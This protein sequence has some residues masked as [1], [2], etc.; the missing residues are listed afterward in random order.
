MIFQLGFLLIVIGGFAGFHM[1]KCRR[2]FSMPVF[3][4]VYAALY[5]VVGIYIYTNE[6]YLGMGSDGLDE[7]W[8]LA[9]VAVISFNLG[10]V[11]FSKRESY[12]LDPQRPGYLP[13]YNALLLVVIFAL[14]VELFVILSVGPYNYFFIS[15]LDRFPIMKQ[16]QPLLYLSNL[17]NIALPFILARYFHTKSRADRNLLVFVLVHNFA[18]AILLISRS[19]LA[20]NFICLFFF[21]ELHG[22]VRKK[23]LLVLGSAMAVLMFFYKGIL[24]GVILDKEYQSFNPGEFINWIRN[25]EIMMNSAFD[26]SWLPNN[27]YFLAFKSMFVISPKEDALSEW[28]INEFYSDRVV[29]GLTYGFSGLIEG[30]LYVG[31]LGVFLHF[32][33][34]GLVFAMLERIRGALKLVVMVSVIFIMF[35]IFRSEIYNFVKTFVWYY[36]Y[37]ALF[38][39]FVD[40][41]LRWYSKSVY[42]GRVRT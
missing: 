29:S 23:T 30:Y 19:A 28:F 8:L 22:V 4:N 7:I 42:L 38:I 21:L 17:I 9:L 37:E 40:R 35:R 24:Y 15:R 13:S 1:L 3:F 11:L 25:S 5:F 32:F 6:V 39:V 12:L 14:T 31:V 2:L 18:L 20:Y 36:A 10:Y 33:V 16:Y 34:I 26:S 41:V 27:S